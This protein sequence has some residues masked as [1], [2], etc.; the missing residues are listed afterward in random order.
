MS[1]A[2]TTPIWTGSGRKIIVRDIAEGQA[3]RLIGDK[4][5]GAPLGLPSAHRIF[6]SMLPSDTTGLLLT[7]DKAYFVYLG[8]TP[9]P[10]IPKYVEFFCVTAGVGL[11]AEE[12]GLFST[13]APPNKSAQAVTKIASSSGITT[14][15]STGMK[16]NS[17]AFNST[18]PAST[19]LWAGIR[20][21]LAVTQPTLI[22]LYNDMAQGQLLTTA[23]AGALTGAGPW[24]GSIITA[25]AVG[26]CP[27]LRATLD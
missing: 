4:L 23:T 16:R 20:T 6:R 5:D 26:V 18:V 17:T 1:F 25:S 7:A 27:D 14:L 21:N 11:E 15:L 24:T 9:G 12:V 3:L 19:H 10:M 2:R 8:Q 13:P 22:S